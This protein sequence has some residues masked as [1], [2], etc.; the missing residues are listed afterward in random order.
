MLACLPAWLTDSQ[1][2]SS[3]VLFVFFCLLITRQTD[4]QQ[5]IVPACTACR[6]EHFLCAIQ[7]PSVCHTI[8][9]RYTCS[10]YD[11]AGEETT[12]G[13]GIVSRK[14]A[15]GFSSNFQRRV[16]FTCRVGTPN[17][18]SLR[19]SLTKWTFS[20]PRGP[21]GP[22]HPFDRNLVPVSYQASKFGCL[23]ASRL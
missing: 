3:L 22:R 13:R 7:R 16:F 14:P 2:C 12:T 1:S 5:Q 15:D 17:F 10:L 6:R 8:S 23:A 21:Y 4:R 11:K 18:K 19:P 20:G 9:A